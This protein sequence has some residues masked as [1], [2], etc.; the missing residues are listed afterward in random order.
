MSDQNEKKPAAPVDPAL[1]VKMSEAEEKAFIEK[2]KSQLSL[3]NEA[4]LQLLAS[5]SKNLP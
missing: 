4:S 2:I 1:L 5:L 3:E